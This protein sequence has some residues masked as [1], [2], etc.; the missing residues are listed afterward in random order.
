LEDKF[1]IPTVL[2]TPLDWGLGHATRCIPLIKTL[3]AKGFRILIGSSGTPAILLQNEFPDLQILPLKGYKIQYSK[4]KWYF[5]FKLLSQLPRII[6]VIQYENKWLDTIIRQYG[7]DLVISDNRFGLHNSRVPCI[8]IT[9]QLTIKTPF[10]WLEKWLQK[11]NYF[12]INKF[13]TC[14]IPDTAGKMNIA[15]ELSHPKQKPAIPLHYIGLL[16]RFEREDHTTGENQ[17]D[18]C[19]MLSGPEPQRT[20]LEKKIVKSLSLVT[21]KILLIRGKPDSTGEIKVPGNTEVRNHL[22][23]DQLQE[24]LRKSS[25]IISRTGYTTVMELLSLQKKTIL[26]PTPGQTEQ[27]YLAKRLLH[28][29][30]CFTVKQSDFDLVT[31]IR[32]A[33]DF[34][35]QPIQL[36]VF[37]NDTLQF[38]LKPLL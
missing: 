15:G 37:N 4:T 22:P 34:F 36:P 11:I 14:W 8:F 24:V 32:K 7:I 30:L 25:L 29:H 19:I 2:I 23:G 21:G 20:L 17:Y 12:Y 10:A 27:E 6:S 26:I 35:Y 3:K 31:A 5:P 16:S 9:H 28:L 1:N 38:I 33:G 13:T 18:Y